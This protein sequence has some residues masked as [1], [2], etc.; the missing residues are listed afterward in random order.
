M[1]TKGAKQD[2]EN[3]PNVPARRSSL[4]VGLSD[5]DDDDDDGDGDDEVKEVV[6]NDR[7]AGRGR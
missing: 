2:V 3:T 1:S 6:D 7:Q 4:G 5:S